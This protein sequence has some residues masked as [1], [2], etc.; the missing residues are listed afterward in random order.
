MLEL[1]D[2]KNSEN[3]TSGLIIYPDEVSKHKDF[4]RTK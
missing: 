4:L 1:L 3:I 2:Q